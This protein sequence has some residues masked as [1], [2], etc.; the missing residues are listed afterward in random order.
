MSG[1]H[2][3]SSLTPVY[4]TWLMTQWLSRQ[5]SCQDLTFERKLERVYAISSSNF[6]LTFY[7]LDEPVSS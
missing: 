1:I 3:S 5:N 6:T 2:E 4:V 7:D